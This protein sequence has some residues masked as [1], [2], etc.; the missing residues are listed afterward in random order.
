MADPRW[1]LDKTDER[2]G[3]VCPRCAGPK[4]IQAAKCWACHVEDVR[5]EPERFAKTLW[6]WRAAHR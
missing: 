5:A 2:W 6:A 4:A 1:R 3:H